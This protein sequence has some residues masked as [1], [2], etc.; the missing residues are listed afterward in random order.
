MRELDAAAVAE[1]LRGEHEAVPLLLDVR[2]AWEL[3]LAAI[4]G[5][6]HIPMNAVPARSRELDPARPLIVMCHHGVRSRLVAS[7]LEANGFQDVANFE[8]GIDAWSRDVDP[9]VPQY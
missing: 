9:T 3:E 1:Q 5:A 6:V 2:E 4:D 8:G 7:W